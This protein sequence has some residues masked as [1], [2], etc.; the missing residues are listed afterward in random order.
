MAMKSMAILLLLL[1][2][3][4]VVPVP[5][6]PPLEVHIEV[7]PRTANGII[8]V[9][10]MP[11]HAS[12]RVTEAGTERTIGTVDLDLEPGGSKSRTETVS[13]YRIVFETKMARD[14]QRAA[15]TATVSKGERIVTRQSSDFSLGR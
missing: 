13:Q 10:T 14:G 2:T 12:A 15:A 11:Y 5:V 9:R 7:K 8:P 1:A 6:E 4:Y 3:S